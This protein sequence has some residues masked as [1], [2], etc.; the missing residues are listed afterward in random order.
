MALSVAGAMAL[1]DRDFEIYAFDWGVAVAPDEEASLEADREFR[2]AA[3]AF[4]E[5]FGKEAPRGAIVDM[6]AAPGQDTGDIA[7]TLPWN[8]D[9]GKGDGPDPK[10]LESV[11]AQI[12]EQMKASG[13]PE[14]TPMFDQALEGAMAQAAAQL[15]GAS[16]TVARSKPLRH[17]IAH[18]LFMTAFWP[19]PGDGL[20]VYAGGAPD[21]LDEAAAVLAEGEEL[22]SRRRKAF[23][24]LAGEG[25]LTPLKEW[26]VMEHPVFAKTKDMLNRDI[27]SGA[28]PR[29][30]AVRLISSKKLKEQG[31][32]I[33]GAADFY[34]QARGFIDFL[35]AEAE[36]G[37]LPAATAHLK[38]GGSMDSFLKEEGRRFGMPRSVER[39][40]D[41]FVAWAASL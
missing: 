28:I 41:A 34:A 38:E 23:A 20:K 7:F 26:F 30:G 9:I 24:R 15:P 12:V 2:A 21:W 10:L 25:G 36:P 35:S 13:I 39:L 19:A 4:E 1:Q 32:D 31:I 14:G 11:R 17:E 5:T 16:K 27:E 8:F 3:G 6:R 33:T 18:Q 22:T 37:F 40:D 29:T